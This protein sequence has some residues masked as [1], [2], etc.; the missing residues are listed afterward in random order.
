MHRHHLTFDQRRGLHHTRDRPQPFGP[1]LE[2]VGRP[3]DPP[4]LVPNT[5]VVDGHM[6]IGAQDR[7]NKLVAKPGPHRQSDD[8]SRHRQRDPDQA[9]PGH[10]ADTAI[11]ALGAQ[12]APCDEE[13]IL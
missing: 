3:G 4:A 12:I 7:G 2:I 9:D 13:F 5:A 10:D 8:Q 6:G 11:G 1:R